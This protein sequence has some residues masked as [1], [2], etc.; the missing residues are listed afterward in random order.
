MHHHALFL[1]TKPF[2]LPFFGGVFAEPFKKRSFLPTS[3][4]GYHLLVFPGSV[5]IQASYTSPPFHF[6]M[7]NRERAPAIFKGLLLF[8][9]SIFWK[10]NQAL[11]ATM[12]PEHGHPRYRGTCLSS[13]FWVKCFLLAL[14][15]SQKRDQ[16]FFLKTKV[17]LTRI[18]HPA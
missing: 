7:I 10:Q 12:K 1:V 16:V 14:V 6:A 15:F 18:F 4:D 13:G 5:H 2:T 8:A 11:M 9:C 17:L 3:S